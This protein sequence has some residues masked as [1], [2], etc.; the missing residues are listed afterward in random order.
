V[1]NGPEPG[2]KPA[3]SGLTG[4][5]VQHAAAVPDATGN[6]WV[7]DVTFTPNGRRLFDQLTRANITAC[8][9]DPATSSSANCPQRHLAIWLDLTQADI[10]S[11]DDATYVAKVTM[12]FDLA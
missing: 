10:A 4:H 7:I 8:P 5:D 11:W 6:A 12:P 1:T 3:L 2:Y 9:S